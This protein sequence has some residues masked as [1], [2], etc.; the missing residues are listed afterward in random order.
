MGV[1]FLIGMAGCG[2]TTLGRA[3]AAEMNVAFVDLDEY[4]EER[5]EATIGEIFKQTGEQTFRE[6]ER[7]ALLE[8]A[9]M[10]D[11]IVACGGGT[12]CQPGNM[13]IINSHGLSI[14]L[15]TNAQ[16]ITER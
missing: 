12:P 16:R 4:I 14:W 2:K 10:D 6:I 13:E 1:I 9:A 11:A 5:C 15:T 7:K 8:V 3:L